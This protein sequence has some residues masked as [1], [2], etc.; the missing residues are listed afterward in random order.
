[1][2][3]TL[4]ITTDDSGEDNVWLV[5]EVEDLPNGEKALKRSGHTVLIDETAQLTPTERNS[6]RQ[7]IQ[8]LERSFFEQSAESEAA[9]DLD[10]IVDEWICRSNVNQIPR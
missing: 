10:P 9:P 5:D 3:N 4:V 8:R 2:P 7:T 6:L 1:M